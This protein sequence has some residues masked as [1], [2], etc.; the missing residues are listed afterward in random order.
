MREEHEM[1]GAEALL[2]AM[3]DSGIEV[4]FANPGTSEMH[5]VSAMGRTDQMRAVLCLFEGVATGAADGYGRMA[6]RPAATLLHVGCGFSNGMANLHN[7]KKAHSPVVNIVGDHATW[8]QPYDAP[9]ATDVPAHARICSDWVRVSESAGDLAASGASAV[10]A[11]RAGA[12]KIATL[13]V[14]ANH[15]WEAAGPPDAK[16]ESV[17]LPG[18]SAACVERAAA[19]LSNGK[20]TGLVLGGRALREGALDAAGRIAGTVGADL[21]CETFPARLQRGAGRVPVRRIPYFAEK[22][23]AFLEAYEQLILVGGKTPVAFFAYPGKPSLLA[24][25][26]CAV[27]TLAAI[28]EDV[29]AALSA[30]ADAL[31]APEAVSGRQRRQGIGAP[32]GALT[33][34]AIGQ[35]LCRLLPENAIVVDE[36]ITCS[37]PIYTATEGAVAHDWLAITGGSIG[38]GL[39]LALGASVACPDRKVVALQADGSAAYTLQALWTM[40]RE[41]SDVTVVLLNNSS[42]GILN[43]ELARVGAGKPN[44]KTLSMFDLGNPALDWVTLARGMGVH[45][46]R[47][48]TAGMFDRQLGEALTAKGPRLIEAVVPVSLDEIFG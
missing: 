13:I 10:A 35:S 46:T 20:R 4:C 22:G 32:E 31:D 5:L 34:G 25:E 24:P 39:P 44:D 19:L 8:H 23:A 43:I 14:P 38:F 9:L 7:A 1:N 36:A 3:V 17:S 40:A 33:P 29:A 47:A 45:A 15:A 21:L 37:Q 11:A 48:E 28:D 30:L 12:G 42:Y 41:Q 6:D 27:E 16:P 18:F 2:A 26:T